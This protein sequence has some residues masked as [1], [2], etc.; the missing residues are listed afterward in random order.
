MMSRRG[1]LC[2]KNIVDFEEGDNDLMLTADRRMCFSSDG[3]WCEEE[4]L[5]LSH[6]KRHLIPMSLEDQLAQWIPIPEDNFT[7]EE[8]LPW[9]PVH[10]RR[11][12]N[13]LANTRSM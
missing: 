3:Q 12:H 5:N 6:K 11:L 13:S 9:C 4:L 1:R 10:C 8:V 7:E 2:S